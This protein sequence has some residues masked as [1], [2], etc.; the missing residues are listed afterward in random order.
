MSYNVRDDNALFGPSA[1]LEIPN[2]AGAPT[3]ALMQIME[4]TSLTLQTAPTSG[5]KYCIF[6]AP[7][8]P[9]AGIQPLG[10]KYQVVG[11]EASWGVASTSGTIQIE[12]CTTG[13]A[14]GSGT[15]LLSGTINGA[16]TAATPVAGALVT[17]AS[18]LTMLATDRLN[19]VFA[20]TTTNWVNV[21]IMVYISRVG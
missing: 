14:D 19:V 1:G 9:T 21:C 12:K 6:I 16:A 18:S 7:P 11:V 5:N 20:G 13:T 3:I 10:A 2:G 15:N 8:S 4:P 17:N